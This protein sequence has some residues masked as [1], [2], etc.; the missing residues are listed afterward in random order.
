VPVRLTNVTVE[1]GALSITVQPM[2]AEER[3]ALL[4]QIREPQSSA[5]AI[6]SAAADV[7]GN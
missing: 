4:D 3:A 7:S 5:A 1:K 6:G 2:T